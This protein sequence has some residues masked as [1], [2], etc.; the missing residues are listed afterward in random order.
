M[1]K[2]KIMVIILDIK[3]WH[4]I[5][6]WRRYN[7]LIIARVRSSTPPRRPYEGPSNVIHPRLVL[8]FASWCRDIGSNG[9]I[10]CPTF[11]LH[12][13]LFFLF[14]LVTV[15]CYVVRHYFCYIIENFIENLIKFGVF[16][17]NYVAR[18]CVNIN[19]VLTWFRWRVS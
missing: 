6:K 4:W 7:V 9:S 18:L 15:I 2:R 12:S 14:P 1:I 11:L 5:D 10:G 8:Q 17:A 13:F 3:K 16:L 19:I